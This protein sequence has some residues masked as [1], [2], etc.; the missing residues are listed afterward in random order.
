M[1][2]PIQ[3]AEPTAL[4]AGD[5][6]Q[7]RREDLSDYPASAWRLTYRF[8][9]AA[10][11]FDLTATADGEAYAIDL[12]PASTG[13]K[14]A[15]WYDWTASVEQWTQDATPVCTARHQ[16]GAGRLQVLPYL[17]NAAAADLRS[18]ARRMVV[19]IEAALEARASTDQLDLVR[20]QLGDRLMQ[21][22][23][24]GDKSLLTQQLEFWEARVA[25]EDRAAR[26]VRSNRILAVG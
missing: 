19:S 11:H 24:E 15:G 8:R 23:M 26:G 14:T 17:S 4:R 3:T 5:T 16:I 21:R 18:F 22:A 20:A 13:N 12:A 6:W 7:W 2:D 9:N 10:S 1:A 25:K